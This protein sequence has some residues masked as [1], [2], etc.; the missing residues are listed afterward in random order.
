MPDSKVKTLLKTIFPSRN[1]VLVTS[2]V[3]STVA[4]PAP[5]VATNSESSTSRADCALEAAIP[6]L[7]IVAAVADGI[8]IAGGPLKGVVNSLLTVLDG[9]DEYQIA[10]SVMRDSS[11]TLFIYLMDAMGHKH[12]IPMNMAQ[13]LEVS[14]LLS[15]RHTESGSHTLKPQQFTFA[16]KALYI[17]ASDRGSLHHR[18]ID[19]NRFHLAINNSRQAIDINNDHDL[20]ELAQPG[21]TVIMSIVVAQEISLSYSNFCP[22]CET[23]LQLKPGNRRFYVC[24]D[25][26]CERYIEHEESLVPGHEAR[27]DGYE[28]PSPDDLEMMKNIHTKIFLVRRFSLHLKFKLH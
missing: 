25:S 20:R 10:M 27:P 15:S 1:N 4:V 24:V 8:P 6:A 26:G 2:V 23:Q 7:R 21:T 9:F 14:M 16:L 28:D 17:R 13:S 11:M 3:S 12:S 5:A 19:S 18:Y 22:V